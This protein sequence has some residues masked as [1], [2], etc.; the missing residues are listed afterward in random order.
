MDIIKILKKLPSGIPKHFIRGKILR[1]SV[2]A[3]LLDIKQIKAN[4]QNSHAPCHQDK[5]VRITE[6][7]I[8]EQTK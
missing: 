8:Y 1:F 6:F 3:I 4:H 7:D 5:T 2:L